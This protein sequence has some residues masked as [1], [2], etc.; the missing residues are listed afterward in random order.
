VISENAEEATNEAD[1]QNYDKVESSTK[2]TDSID[3]IFK[4]GR[5]SRQKKKILM[6]G[7]KK[8]TSDVSSS[9]SRE[10]EIVKL[11]RNPLM[12]KTK[13]SK[14]VNSARKSK[15]QNTNKE[16]AKKYANKFDL[17]KV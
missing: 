5:T 13:E 7:G 4:V 3:K 6:I 2:V 16:L 9:E 12:L 1:S 14:D 15:G 17:G 11:N 10:R 8:I